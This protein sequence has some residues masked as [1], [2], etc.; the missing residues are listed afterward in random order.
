M[1]IRTKGFAAFAL[2][3][4]YLAAALPAEAEEQSCYTRW[5]SCES[6]CLNRQRNHL[7]ACLNSCNLSAISC[8]G[9]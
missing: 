7:S 2:P 4:T 8:M 5:L 3:L 9:G 6:F 1:H